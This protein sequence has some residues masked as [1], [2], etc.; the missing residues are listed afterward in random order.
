MKNYTSE[1]SIQ[2]KTIIPP[3]TTKSINL[4]ILHKNT[5]ARMEKPSTPQHITKLPF[6]SLISDE[7]THIRRILYYKPEI[8]AKSWIVMD[9]SSGIQIDGFNENEVREIASLSKIMTCI[10]V[11]QEAIKLKKKYMII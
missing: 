5:T 3:I 10:V 11:I 7:P 6:L 4:N 8:S 9:G 1:S 2:G